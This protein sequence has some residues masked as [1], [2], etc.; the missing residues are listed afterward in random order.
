[1]NPWTAFAAAVTLVFGAAYSLWMYKRVVF[2]PVANHEVAQLK[3][4][5]AREFLML[6]LLALLTLWMGIQPKPFTDVTE[7]SVR[8]LLEHVSV[9]K[10]K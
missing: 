7:A 5:N 9:S 1:F 4:I 8:A 3:D 10:I 6:A 2:G